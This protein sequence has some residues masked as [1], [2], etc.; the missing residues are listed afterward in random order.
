MQ[1]RMR[2]LKGDRGHDERALRLV[3]AAM[4]APDGD[5]VCWWHCWPAPP[6]NCQPTVSAGSDDSARS[7]PSAGPDN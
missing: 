6:A 3:G 4:A 2:A 5:G 7:G 1:S